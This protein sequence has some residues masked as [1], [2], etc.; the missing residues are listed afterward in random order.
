ML[1]EALELPTS[2]R[3]HAALRA[4]I[5]LEELHEHERAQLARD[6]PRLMATGID[7]RW[8]GFLHKPHCLQQ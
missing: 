1:S 8:V 7:P 5:L 3:L 4:N 6:I 2:T